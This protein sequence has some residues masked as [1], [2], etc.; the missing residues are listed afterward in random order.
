MGFPSQEWDI[1][2][3]EKRIEINPQEGTTGS[4]KE[5]YEVLRK[6]FAY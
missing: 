5:C 1:M 2:D 4:F 3:L 6:K